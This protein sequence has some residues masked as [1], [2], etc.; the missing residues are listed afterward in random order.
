MDDL[1]IA[2]AA[3]QVARAEGNLGSGGGQSSAASVVDER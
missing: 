1:P 2:K 3:H